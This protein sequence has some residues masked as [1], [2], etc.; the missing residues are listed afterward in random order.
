MVWSWKRLPNMDLSNKGKWVA[1]AKSCIM[2]T[3]GIMRRFIDRRTVPCCLE[4]VSEDAIT[5]FS[6]L[7][8]MLS[9]FCPKSS[10][11]TTLF[12]PSSVH[13]DLKVEQ[14]S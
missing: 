3:E 11:F 7:V 14:I 5:V 6:L 8:F 12:P 4:V 9:V 13:Q 1:I 2:S 10:R